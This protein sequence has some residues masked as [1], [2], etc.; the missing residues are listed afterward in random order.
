[1]PPKGDVVTENEIQLSSMIGDIQIISKQDEL[2]TY[3]NQPARSYH[4]CLFLLMNHKQI[5]ASVSFIQ[6]ELELIV[7]ERL[8]EHPSIEVMKVDII[9]GWKCELEP[10]IRQVSLFPSFDKQVEENREPTMLLLGL[11]SFANEVQYRQDVW[12]WMKETWG[13][14]VSFPVDMYSN[15]VLVCFDKSASTS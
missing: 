4:V 10:L 12:K 3:E 5:L 7:V 13:S 2:T 11:R 14:A 1:M 15:S 8:N 6:F 9:G